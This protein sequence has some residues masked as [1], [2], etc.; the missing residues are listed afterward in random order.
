LSLNVF[1]IDHAL[2]SDKLYSNQI[3]TRQNYKNQLM[4]SKRRVNP[5]DR[6]YF[7]ENPWPNGHR[8]ASFEWSAH[9]EIGNLAKPGF[10]S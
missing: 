1:P 3:F 4:I 10:S 2:L 6:I 5:M 7:A 8:I 9:F